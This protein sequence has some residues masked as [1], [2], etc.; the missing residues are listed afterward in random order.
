MPKSQ[1][2]E[3]NEPSSQKIDLKA[4]KVKWSDKID[5]DVLQELEFNDCIGE[6]SFAR[7]YQAFDNLLKKDVAVKVIDKRK[8]QDAKRKKVV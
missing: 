2:K 5:L 8:L 6:G 4:V 1:K 7:V 3:Y